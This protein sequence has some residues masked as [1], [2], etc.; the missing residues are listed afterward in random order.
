MYRTNQYI[1]NKVSPD[2]Y[3]Q[4]G[5]LFIENNPAKTFKK[6]KKTNKNKKTYLQFHD[7]RRTVFHQRTFH[8]VSLFHR[9]INNHMIIRRRRRRR[10]T[11][12]TRTTTSTSPK[13][14]IQRRTCNKKEKQKCQQFQKKNKKKRQK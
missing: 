11:R 6:I 4:K 1:L 12:T 2:I 8:H 13:E 5:S 10:S 14:I 3:T 9:L 7:I